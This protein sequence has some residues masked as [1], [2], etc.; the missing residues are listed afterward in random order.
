MSSTEFDSEAFTAEATRRAMEKAVLE[1]SVR[2]DKTPTESQLQMIA[3]MVT[4]GVTEAMVLLKEMF[5][6][7]GQS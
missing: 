5:I 4:L 2:A 1:L 6:T 3:A 7:G